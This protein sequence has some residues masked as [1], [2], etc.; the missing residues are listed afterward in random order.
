M[1][2]TFEPRNISRHFKDHHAQQ[3]LMRRVKPANKATYNMAVNCKWFDFIIKGMFDIFEIHS[4]T[5]TQ[6]HRP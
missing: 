6:S 4:C 1:K 3:S 2:K 5:N